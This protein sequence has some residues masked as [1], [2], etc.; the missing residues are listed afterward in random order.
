MRNFAIPLI[1]CL[2]RNFNVLSLIVLNPRDK[3]DSNNLKDVCFDYVLSQPQNKLFKILYR[4]YA[5]SLRNQIDL[6]CSTNNISKI[7][8]M[9]GDTLISPFL[10]HL[11][12]KYDVYYTVHDLFPHYDP[13]L[14]IRKK[15]E[16]YFFFQRHFNNLL[17]NNNNLITCSLNQYNYMK[18]HMK[19]KNVFFHNF[20]SLI[21]SIDGKESCPELTDINSNY[22]LFFSH[23]AD[24]KGVDLLY[25]AFIS[26]KK[27]QKFKLVI[28]GSGNIY[29]DR[30]LDLEDNVIFIN[31]FIKD[32]EI[33]DIF[34]RCKAVVYPYKSA[35]QSGN[36]SYVYFYGK[37]LLLSDIPYFKE[38]TNAGESVFFKSND[39]NDLKEKLEYLMFDVNEEAM[40]ST[41]RKA[42]STTFSRNHISDQLLSIFN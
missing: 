11:Q 3:L 30:K 17:R 20:P 42:Y 1:K 6:I 41:Q 18:L 34:S 25:N 21:E 36:T 31:R 32:T 40:V 19:E 15:I 38:I 8:L 16:N 9:T 28:A 5:Y 37:L 29:F 39:C 27:L 26:S 35:T 4:I 22:I 12:S 7:W 23:I 24:Y 14:S 2:K 13:N 10:S 33:P